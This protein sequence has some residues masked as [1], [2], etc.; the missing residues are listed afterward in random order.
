M[1]RV[2]APWR[3][4]YI[5]QAAS[6]NG[7]KCIFCDFLKS[8]SDKKNLVLY[9]NK[10]G[11]VM[12]NKYPYNNGHV[13]VTPCKHVARFE[14]LSE[15]EYIGFSD[16]LRLSVKVLEHVYKPQG[17][18]IGMNLGKAAGAGVDKHIHYHIVQDGTAI[19]ILCRSLQKQRSSLSILWKLMI[20]LVRDLRR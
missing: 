10:F 16:L 17:L 2:W 4:E 3:G 14:S 5:K 19:P 12:M 7:S 18:N 9:K 20:D 6:D 15:K 8:K 11:L 1:E 13:M